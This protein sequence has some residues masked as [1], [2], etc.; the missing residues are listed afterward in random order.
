MYVCDSSTSGELSSLALGSHGMHVIGALDRRSVYSCWNSV[1]LLE[2]MQADRINCWREY[3]LRAV[4]VVVWGLSL[5]SAS[6]HCVGV[7]EH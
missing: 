2:A 3:N 4:Y 1:Y 6:W 5:L 7:F